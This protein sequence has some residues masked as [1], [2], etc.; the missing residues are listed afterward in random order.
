MPSH[1]Q[2]A[3]K[4]RHTVA[5]HARTSVSN[6]ACLSLAAI[7]AHAHW[8]NASASAPF[9][10]AR[11]RGPGD[12]DDTHV[13]HRHSPTGP[14]LRGRRAAPGKA[15]SCME[16]R[17]VFLLIC[18]EALYS[19]FLPAQAA[20]RPG[21]ARAEKTRAH[22]A[23]SEHCTAATAGMLSCWLLQ[24]EEPII[25]GSEP[26]QRLQPQRLQQPHQQPQ[27][28]RTL[29]NERQ[30]LAPLGLGRC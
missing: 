18:E 13:A 10:R 2:H 24:V 7:L 26:P 21:S 12:G 28:R 3:N 20:S 17:L 23:Q 30:L 1:F 4:V 5:P 16:C 14:R 8:P 9:C 11:K 27:Q 19:S 15:G 22:A 29:G 25:D 6:M